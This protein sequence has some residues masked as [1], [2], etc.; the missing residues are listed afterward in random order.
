MMGVGA[1][2]TGWFLMRVGT[3]LEEDDDDDDE[4]EEAIASLAKTAGG[5]R[6]EADLLAQPWAAGEREA[7]RQPLMEAAVDMRT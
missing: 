2:K 4:E 6:N 5:A 1:A 3:E 7:E